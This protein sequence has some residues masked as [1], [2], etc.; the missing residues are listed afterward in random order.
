MK[1]ST[2]LKASASFGLAASLFLPRFETNNSPQ[3]AQCEAAAAEC[4]YLGKIAVPSA[5]VLKPDM[6]TEQRLPPHIVPGT[7]YVLGDSLSAGA[8]KLTKTDSLEQSL[9]RHGWRDVMVQAACGR[10]LL[11]NRQ[12]T[13]CEEG[14]PQLLTGHARIQEPADQAF[15]AKSEA[16]ILEL[17]TNDYY[18]DPSVFKA[19]AQQL[20][21]ELGS[22]NPDLQIF[23]ATT[24]LD[25]AVKGTHFQAINQVIQ[26]LGVNV[27]DYAS[28]A[29]PF[30]MPTCS[31]GVHPLCNGGF[32]NFIE[33][34]TDKV[35]SPASR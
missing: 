10:P 1:T 23:W 33:V 27:I 16:I 5:D 19:S 2:L 35:G 4:A 20:L 9:T 30:T 28:T 22:I 14:R 26:E 25:P 6:E 11:G 13:S 3:P 34:I 12:Y 29:A 31:D 18:Q 21:T 32:A 8:Q 17:G 7:I 24:Y 15:I